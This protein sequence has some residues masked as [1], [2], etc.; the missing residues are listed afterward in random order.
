MIFYSVNSEW[1]L[2]SKFTKIFSFSPHSLSDLIKFEKH[3]ESSPILLAFDPYSPLYSLF[4]NYYLKLV[5]MEI[6]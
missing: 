2:L 1:S 5:N 3:L 6:F 4:L